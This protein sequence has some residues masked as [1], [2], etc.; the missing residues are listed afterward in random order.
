MFVSTS[1]KRQD[2]TDKSCCIANNKKRYKMKDHRM[3][4]QLNK[5]QNGSSNLC[6][7]RHKCYKVQMCSKESQP[8]DDSNREAF[9]CTGRL[10]PTIKLHFLMCK[11]G[12]HVVLN[13]W[14]E[15]ALAPR[16]AIWIWFV[17]TKPGKG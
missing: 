3:M 17:K 5:R 16:P 9:A 2:T 11:L 13:S 12:N 7:I 10:L 1:W 14:L 4:R 8:V 6:T 15:S